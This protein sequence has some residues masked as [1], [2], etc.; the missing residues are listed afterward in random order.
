MYK[1]KD[2]KVCD[3]MTRRPHVMGTAQFPQKIARCLTAACPQ[4]FTFQRADSAFVSRRCASS[5]SRASR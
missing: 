3:L 4:S 2:A 1:L 5:L